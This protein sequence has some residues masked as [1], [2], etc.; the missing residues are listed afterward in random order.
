MTQPDTEV[1]AERAIESGYLTREDYEECRRT[2]EA[3]KKLG[4]QK[5]VLEA[6][7]DHQLLT[8]DQIRS[9]SVHAVEPSEAPPVLEPEKEPP[10]EPF[11]M[12]FT[13]A[14]IEAML[15]E[16]SPENVE[17]VSESDLLGSANS[18]D[19]PFEGTVDFTPDDLAYATANAR[20]SGSSSPVPGS[21]P[22]PDGS[23]PGVTGSS[24][25]SSP[26][27]RSG[28]SAAVVYSKDV[29][30]A[31][32]VFILLLSMV[33][34]TSPPALG[35]STRKVSPGMGWPTASRATTSL[36]A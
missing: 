14:E 18:A 23:L 9:L 25:P 21:S 16:D 29:A 31:Y 17:E 22:L 15:A 34:T 35:L 20:E 13:E 2:V 6:L 24:V 33:S 7:T 8:E 10:S 26:S 19:A 30:A 36:P 28:S 4:V 11:A 32:A 1:I 27:S 12:D 5:T 3:L